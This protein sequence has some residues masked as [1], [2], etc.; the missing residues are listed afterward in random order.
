MKQVLTITLAATILW[1]ITAASAQHD[2]QNKKPQLSDDQRA[3]VDQH[4]DTVD[5][6]REQIDQTLAAENDDFAALIGNTEPTFQER[7]DL[8]RL[9][10]EL[11]EQS[12]AAQAAVG[13]IEVV[14]QQFREDNNLPLPGIHHL[15]SVANPK[16]IDVLR[17]PITEKDQETLSTHK[18]EIQEK[19]KDLNDLLADESDR[20][21]ELLAKSK[22]DKKDLTGKE[23]REYR[24]LRKQLIADNEA[25]QTLVDG[26]HEANVTF[27]EANPALGRQFGKRRNSLRRAREDVVAVKAIQ[28]NINDILAEENVAFAGL[29]KQVEEGDASKEVRIEFRDLRLDLIETTPGVA[30]LDTG[31]KLL[32][33]RVQH[34]ARHARHHQGGGAVER[35]VVPGGA[36]T[37]DSE[38]VDSGE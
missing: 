29:L 4:R 6:L 21:A 5:A 13:E 7:R 36:P 25:A 23:R 20:Y 3:A 26:I 19:H 8:A 24:D 33:K 17:A 16:R 1:T 35:P 22:S 32:K 34:R 14:N 31:A 12:D 27:R 9:R 15:D 2:Q 38:D 30:E 11:L 37:D 10:K 18:D 28:N